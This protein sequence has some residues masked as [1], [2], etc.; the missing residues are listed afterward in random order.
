MKPQDP[1]PGTPTPPAGAGVDHADAPALGGAA[2]LRPDR[3]R[4]HGLRKAWVLRQR[5]T[6]RMAR[7]WLLH[8]T[9]LGMIAGAGAIAFNW[10]LHE[11]AHHTVEGMMGVR[12]PAAGSARELRRVQARPPAA[13]STLWVLLLPTLGGLASGLLCWRFAPEAMGH[14]TD[15]AIHAFHQKSGV[16]RPAVP[17]TKL[18]ATVCTL[19]CGGSGG[20][21]GPIAQIGS[22]FGSILGQRLNLGPRRTRILLVA[23]MGA[24]VAALFEA[25]LAAMIFAGEI[26]YRGADIDG[27][28][29]V[30]TAIASV[31]SYSCYVGLL[32]MFSGVARWSHMFAV[33]DW[34]FA[35]GFELIGYT[36]LA[37]ACAAM[38][39]VWIRVYYGVE[40][41]FERLPLPPWLRPA[42]GGFLTGLLAL[43]TLDAAGGGPGAGIVS[44]GYGFLQQ[45]I[46]TQ[47]TLG[48]ILT[49]LV[50][51][52]LAT[53]CS[54]GSGGSGGIF[55]PSLVLG[56]LLG[57]A[58]GQLL[59]GLDP[60]LVA[61]PGSYAVI[62]MAGLFAA[63]AHAPVCSVIMVAEITRSYGLLVPSIWVCTLAFMLVG[64]DSLYVRQVEH[65]EDSP[66]HQ[67]EVR[68]NV[69]EDLT[70]GEVMRTQVA[71]MS[72]DD[73]YASIQDVLLHHRFSKFP[74]L[75][76]GGRLAGVLTLSDL[77][78][79]LDVPELKGVLVAEDAMQILRRWVTP[80]TSLGEALRVLDE[81][82]WTLLCVTAEGD[83]G[84]LEGVLTRRDILLAY[85][86][87]LERRHQAREDF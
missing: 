20:V 60:G 62:G 69:L 52:M 79:V 41:G 53:A 86:A 50:L 34:H 28:V 72:V 13:P 84:Q 49:L 37:L 10:L 25:P 87:E 44:G 18:A 67:R 8:A 16:V 68:W 51:K 73:D 31:V 85:T 55:G 23:G 81:E 43:L 19:G 7:S 33:P 46:D 66:A 17:L 39:R 26:L 77:R 45:A 5:L 47:L 15:G 21:E 2:T 59:H 22:G 71:T 40:H 48:L 80:S 70:C 14:G 64:E 29:L 42:L 63:A 32:S 75:D 9:L 4:R 3:R 61:A 30:P 1:S 78:D 56:G 6:R 76:R 27:E 74:V 38:A 57:G 82:E 54:I 83:P 24:G 36:A 58:V 65:L 12:P 35:S 11:V